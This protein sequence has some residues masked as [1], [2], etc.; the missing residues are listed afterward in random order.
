MSGSEA[1]L[2]PPA[3]RRTLLVGI[4]WMV[5]CSILS[6]AMQAMVRQ[7]ASEIHPFEI[8]FFRHFLGLFLLAAMFQ[9]LGWKALRTSNWGMHALRAAANAVAMMAFFVGLTLAPFANVTALGFAAPLFAAMGAALFLGEKMR[10]RRWIA[11]L[12]GFGG[13]LVIVRPGFA[14]VG[15]GELL[16]LFSAVGW[17]VALLLIKTMSRTESALTITAYMS[18]LLSPITLAF[19]VFVWTWPSLTQL[20]WLSGIACLGTLGQF[21]LNQA[22]RRGEMAVVMPVEFV[23]VIWAALIGMYIFGEPPDAWV[24]LGAAIIVASTSYIAYR[25]SRVKGRVETTPAPPA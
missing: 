3:H 19:A 12:A 25:E 14:Q 17:A 6:V 21:S 2:H 18:L 15:L 5:L 4:G 13:V 7:I 8:A 22:L 11:T 24:G 16:V 23:R 20:L 10:L 9:G 1:P